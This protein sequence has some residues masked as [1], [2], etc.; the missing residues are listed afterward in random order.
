MLTMTQAIQVHEL[1]YE[2]EI[3]TMCTWLILLRFASE[4]VSR[5]QYDYKWYASLS[6][7]H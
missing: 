6:L 7:S 1:F 4:A 2:V 3:K 5:I